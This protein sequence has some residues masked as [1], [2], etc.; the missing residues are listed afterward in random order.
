MDLLSCMEIL[1]I[2]PPRAASTIVEAC[3]NAAQQL[4]LESKVKNGDPGTI[5]R[6]YKTRLFP[7]LT[8]YFINEGPNK[9]LT[10]WR[11]LI[12]PQGTASSEEEQQYLK[13]VSKYL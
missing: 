3:V 4:G 7:Y 12:P 9:F 5:I 8:L 13:I 1:D 10:S 2:K 6:V 11:G